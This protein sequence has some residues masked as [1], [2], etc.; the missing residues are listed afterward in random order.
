MLGTLAQDLKYSVQ[1]P[2]LV[3]FSTGSLLL[4]SVYVLVRW[5]KRP[6]G[7]PES[8][9]MSTVASYCTRTIRQLRSS[10][11]SIAVSQSLHTSDPWMIGH[12]HLGTVRVLVGSPPSNLCTRT[13]RVWYSTVPHRLQ[14]LSS[15]GWRP[16]WLIRCTGWA[17]R[18]AEG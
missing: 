18:V 15:P 10:A 12:L 5:R 4:P 2:S 14:A 11:A 6:T 8:Q 17:D 1:L 13:G 3:R 16:S 9:R 7:F